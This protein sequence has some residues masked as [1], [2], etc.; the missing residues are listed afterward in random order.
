FEKYGWDFDKVFAEMNNYDFYTSGGHQAAKDFVVD[1]AAKM[2]ARN[3]AAMNTKPAP[4]VTVTAE[5]VTVERPMSGP[6]APVEKVKSAPAEPV[7]KTVS[8]PVVNVEKLAP[9]AEKSSTPSGKAPKPGKKSSL[10][11]SRRH[12]KTRRQHLDNNA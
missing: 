2:A 3:A 11:G 7:E 8:A 4:A 10:I 6:S 12:V 1:Y 9:P 5:P